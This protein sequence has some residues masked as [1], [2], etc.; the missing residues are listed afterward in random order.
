MAK[1][2]MHIKG[3]LRKRGV[4]LLGG[5][6]QA[7]K[8]YVAI[9]LA[10]ALAT[11]GAFFGKPVPEP[12]GVVYAAAEGDDTIQP[13][14]IAAQ[15]AQGI[16]DDALLPICVF[17]DFRM[18]RRGDDRRDM[19]APFVAN[20]ASARDAFEERGM[21]APG[22]IMIDTAS[23]GIDMEDENANSVIAEVI[24]RARALG[25]QTG[26]LVIIVHH[27]GK[28]AAKKL[29]GGS[30]WFANSDQVLSVISQVD[31]NGIPQNPRS[32]FL[33][34]LRGYPAGHIGNFDLV[35]T[36]I[37]Q[38]EDGDDAIE[39]HIRVTT[40]GE[41]VT[42]AKM[43][44]ETEAPKR[45][46]KGG[47]AFRDAFAEAL[48]RGQDRTIQRGGPGRVVVRMARLEDVREQFGRI[49]LSDSGT[50]AARRKAWSR[51]LDDINRKGLGY[52]TEVDRDGVAWIWR[53]DLNR[54]ADMRGHQLAVENHQ[55]FDAEIS[56]L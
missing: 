15:R 31:E 41:A 12:I 30:A 20:V 49:Y 47:K 7:G 29:R 9:A 43:K 55:D 22:V 19:F 38:D 26:M 10:L 52:A 37:G 50:P 40:G 23:A 16:D 34:K 36:I 25:E 27:F 56:N 28:D 21:P 32:L 33:D 14:L 44:P 54:A 5:Q 4:V 18:P 35:P 3:L 48:H 45:E 8:S 24:D 39:A 6:S 46:G 2:P 53:P 51:E 11:G 13:R 17:Q 1:P 42:V